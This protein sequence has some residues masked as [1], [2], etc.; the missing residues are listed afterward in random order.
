MAVLCLPKPPATFEYCMTACKFETHWPIGRQTGCTKAQ[1]ECKE[2]CMGTH[3]VCLGAGA[4]RAPS[5]YSLPDAIAAAP[6]TAALL[7][8]GA[9]LA[10]GATSPR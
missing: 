8:D 3:D 5:H 10:P 1:C 9:P 2:H 7:L 6:G 4:P